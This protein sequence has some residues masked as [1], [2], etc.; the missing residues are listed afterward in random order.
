MKQYIGLV[1]AIAM[2][3]I[4]S[5]TLALAEM[6]VKKNVV[7][8]PANEALRQALQSENWLMSKINRSAI[9]PSLL[10]MDNRHIK[11]LKLAGIAI[12]SN[13][14]FESEIYRIT[15]DLPGATPMGER[16]LL[17]TLRLQV[18]ILE[19]LAKEKGVLND[20]SY[21]EHRLM[22][23]DREKIFGDFRDGLIG[24]VYTAMAEIALVQTKLD[25]K[26]RRK[27]AYPIGI[28]SKEG[29]ERHF[30][31]TLKRLSAES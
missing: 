4:T 6:S 1:S 18:I 2:I 29:V 31:Y 14:D 23:P 7:A 3:T 26:A 12:E 8:R 17:Y 11:S 20:S 9:L 15:S 28:N 21:K 13:G 19:R 10:A 16:L 22:S 25:G 24:Y 5:P 27:I 30:V